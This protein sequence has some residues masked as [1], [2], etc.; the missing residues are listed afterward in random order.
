M[1]APTISESKLST[2]YLTVVP[3]EIRDRLG[4]QEG[5]SLRWELRGTELLVRIRKRR[6]LADVT[7]IGASG[8]DAVVSKRAV[9]GL[10]RRVR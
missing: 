1:V 3:K 5:D 8:G 6:T 2:G 7:G 4:A 9:Q 10:E